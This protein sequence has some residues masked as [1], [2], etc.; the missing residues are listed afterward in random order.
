MNNLI[1]KIN[2]IHLSHVSST[3]Q[4]IYQLAE[5]D[6]EAWT[7]L[8]CDHQTEGKGYAA[9]VWKTNAYQNATFSFVLK[10]SLDLE[11]DLPMLNM[12]IAVQ[13]TEFLT[14]W[15][16]KAKVKWPNDIMINNKKLGGILIENKIRD[17]KTKFTVIGIGINLNQTIFDQNLKNATSLKLENNMENINIEIFIKSMMNQFY[18]NYD[19][20]LGKKY[21]EILTKY[22][23]Y[24]YRKNQ[25]SVFE[26]NG[27]Q[28]NGI[29][30]YVNSKGNII[31]ELEDGEK[32]FK[33]KQIALL[34]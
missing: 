15:Q 27:Y 5:K 26:I 21:D 24:L 10:D 25:I 11:I 12:W 34:K 8:W 1:N 33:H 7:V 22:N 17:Q 18:T 9:N 14:K 32:E 28:Q 19:L 4:K 2:Y 31:I 29:I 23:H 20:I 3:N 16:V 6:C 13:I 30:R